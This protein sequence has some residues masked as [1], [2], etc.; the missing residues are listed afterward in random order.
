ME[1]QMILDELTELLSS[2][3]VG[4]RTEAMDGRQGGL[5]R[6]NDRDIFFVDTDSSPSDA[7]DACA[8]AVSEMV[9]TDSIYIRPVIR[10]LIENQ[11]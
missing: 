4:I 6:I 9:D 11:T 5:C 10:E 3:G 8:K 2:V 7:I 1:K